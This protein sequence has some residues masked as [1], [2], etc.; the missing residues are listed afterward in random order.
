[1][2][3]LYLSVCPSICLSVCLSVYQVLDKLWPVPPDGLDGLEDVDLPVLDDLLDARVRG[4]VHA[5]PTTGTICSTVN[6]PKY[7]LFSM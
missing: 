4:A 7:Q 1:M 6:Y 3:D 2:E 5:A